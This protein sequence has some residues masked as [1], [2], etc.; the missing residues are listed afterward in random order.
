MRERRFARPGSSLPPADRLA[1]RLPD[2]RP[3]L[4]KNFFGG[5]VNLVFDLRPVEEHPLG[6]PKIESEF[7]L[8]YLSFR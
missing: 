1:C 8:Q 5:G 4:G 6:G 7:H 3:E 2:I